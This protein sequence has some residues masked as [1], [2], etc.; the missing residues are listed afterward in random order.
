MTNQR[1]V[2]DDVGR[3]FIMNAG[4]SRIWMGGIPQ[5]VYSGKPQVSTVLE[6]GP[7]WKP[8]ARIGEATQNMGIT[9]TAFMNTTETEGTLQIHR[10]LYQYIK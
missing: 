5:G 7:W 3:L 6:K 8:R 9:S 2:I 1:L 4:L 10:I